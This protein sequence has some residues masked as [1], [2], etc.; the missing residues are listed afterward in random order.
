MREASLAHDLVALGAGVNAQVNKSVV[1]SAD[2]STQIG[3]RS[4]MYLQQRY[5]Y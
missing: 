5:L 1:M 3:W 2:A 4:S